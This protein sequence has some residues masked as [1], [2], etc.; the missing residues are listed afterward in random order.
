MQ[1]SGDVLQQTEEQTAAHR[2]DIRSAGVAI[3]H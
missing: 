1:K 3:L 2:Q